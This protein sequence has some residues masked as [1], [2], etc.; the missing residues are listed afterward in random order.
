M[1]LLRFA[2]KVIV[3][4]AQLAAILSC[5]FIA[6]ITT[7]DVILRSFF[8]RPILGVSELNQSVLAILLGFGFIICVHQR[9][10]IR[11]TLFE[12]VIERKLPRWVYRGWITAWEV[13]VTSI[14][15]AL[16]WRH[17]QHLLANYEYSAV[18]DIS[19]GAVFIVVAT[20]LTTAALVLFLRLIQPKV[21]DVT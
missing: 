1:K 18:L 4:V 19:M 14:F 12:G 10:H 15:A 8:H 9:A 13:V 20:L 21:K 7:I 3:F 11:V 16:I 2:M 5:A 17:A 6:V